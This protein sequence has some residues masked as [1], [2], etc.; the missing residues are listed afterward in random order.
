MTTKQDRADRRREDEAEAR[1]DGWTA[2]EGGL[3]EAVVADG[4][5]SALGRPPDFLRASARLVCAGRYRVN[6]FTGLHAGS[7]RVSHSYF[8][9]ADGNGKVLASSPPLARAY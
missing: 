7:A 2:D 6:V 8:V 3:L 1:R 5:M 9:E 4:V